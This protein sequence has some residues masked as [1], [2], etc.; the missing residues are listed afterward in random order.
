VR[1]AVDVGDQLIPLVNP[2]HSKSA[3]TG[4]LVSDIYVAEA[5]TYQNELAKTQ[6][7]IA[8]LKDIGWA[9]LDGVETASDMLDVAREIGRPLT[10]PTGK[11][12]KALKPMESRLARQGSLSA[13]CGLDEFPFHTD[14]AFW[15]R[16]SRYLVMRVEGDRRRSTSLLHFENVLSTIG[17]RARSDVLR[18]IWRTERNKGGIY[19]SMNF[20]AGLSRGWRYD[21]NVMRPTNPSS[22]RTLENFACA[23]RASQ[24]KVTVSWERTSCL[25]VDNWHLLHA[26]G[27]APPEELERV[28]FRI[29]VG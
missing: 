17:P 14:T 29:Y 24:E 26:R 23:I 20:S 19:C 8:T 1:G 13:N 7:M 12:V 2:S 9:V 18:S 22:I 11:V 16:P 6:G 3:F 4:I 15:A 27:A 21:P 28:L 10:S 25:V 5:G